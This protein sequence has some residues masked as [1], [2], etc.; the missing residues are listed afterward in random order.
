V[1]IKFRYHLRTAGGVYKRH[2]ASYF[3]YEILVTFNT[4]RVQKD[5]GKETS[6]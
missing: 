1:I 3:F 4:Y 6:N 5:N 2:V